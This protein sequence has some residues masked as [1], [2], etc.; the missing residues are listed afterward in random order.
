MYL[1]SY[2]LDLLALSDLLVSGL[3]SPLLGSNPFHSWEP[4]PKEDI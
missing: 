4:F 3:S 2:S 1:L